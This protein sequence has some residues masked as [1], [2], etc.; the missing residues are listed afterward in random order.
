M[1][2]TYDNKC[3]YCYLEFDQITES[4]KIKCDFC[5]QFWCSNKC[6]EKCI[7]H[8][9]QCMNNSDKVT[10]IEKIKANGYRDL[11]FEQFSN[12][13]LRFL[14]SKLYYD[15]WTKVKKRIAIVLTFSDL[16][17]ALIECKLIN[18]L[19]EQFLSEL[20]KE[21]WSIFISNKLVP[22]F[23]IVNTAKERSSRLS[24][25]Y[26]DHYRSKE[27]RETTQYSHGIFNLFMIWKQ[28]NI[29]KTGDK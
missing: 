13:E 25:F 22:V 16:N 20:Q 4:T 8:N 10:D 18:E 1:D 2:S 29:E 6:K 27:K 7:M 28:V 17:L 21:K 15:V 5:S 9:L 24:L 11:I 12:E 23:V 26:S 19:D 14:L 3:G